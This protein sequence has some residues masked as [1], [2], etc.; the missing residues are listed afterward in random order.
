VKNTSAESD[1][2]VVCTFLTL[3]AFL[4][5]LV[6][7]G[8]DSDL[9]IASH[10]EETRV[11]GAR[12]TLATEPGRADV[13]AGQTAVVEWFVAGP[14]APTSLDWVFALCTAIDGACVDTPQLAGTGSG[15]PIV[16]PFT[17][18]PAATLVDGRSPL[19]VGVICV[20]GTLGPATA[21][22]V[23]T[24]TGSN[25][26]AT[27]ARFVIPVASASAAANHHPNVANDELD[28]AGVLWD[29]A[30][31]ATGVAGDPCDVTAGLPVV[32]PTAA[33][34]KEVEQEIRIVSDGDDRESFTPAGGSTPVL[35]EL[36][37]SN[38]A[39]S[40]KF[41]ASYAAI[42]STDT[43]PDADATMKWVPPDAKDVPAVGKIVQLHFVVRDGRGGLDWTH[44]ALCVRAP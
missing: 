11:L 44:R 12:V 30:T 34:A 14:R 9:P 21:G 28:L 22:A 35:E 4:V 8:C 13:Q 42:F 31:A 5:L 38:F 43:R 36:Q 23:A 40:G 6:S 26:S 20:D 29:P 19:M 33:G 7:G 1:G 15:T 16:V 25:A 27:E 37:I 41:D 39:A 17:T 2:F 3:L 24:C 32:P 18:P 10:L